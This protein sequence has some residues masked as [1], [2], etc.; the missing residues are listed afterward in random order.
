MSNSGN[1][2]A[3][4]AGVDR[5]ED[6]CVIARVL[7]VV[8]VRDEER[9]LPAELWCSGVTTDLTVDLRRSHA[10]RYLADRGRDYAEKEFSWLPSR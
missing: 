2:G 3:R 7:L 9:L 6:A 5:N 10:E 4:S 8:P 1:D